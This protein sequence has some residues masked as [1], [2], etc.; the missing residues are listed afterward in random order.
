MQTVFEKVRQAQKSAPVDVFGLARSLGVRVNQSF[1]DSEISGELVRVGQSAFEINVNANHATTRQ[2]FTAAHELGHFIFHRNLIGDGLDDDRA[3]RSTQAGRF[4][5]PRIG[6]KQESEANQ[7][8]ASLLM[9]HDLVKNMEAEGLSRRQMA[10]RLGV[11][12][13]AMAIRLGQPYP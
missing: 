9:P 12:E 2:R 7:F 10:D 1:L 8:A 6:P 4:F 5:N 13:H 11:S 3:Y